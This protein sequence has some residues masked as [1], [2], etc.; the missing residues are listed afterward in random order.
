MMSAGL[1]AL[2]TGVKDAKVSRPPL[3]PF[4]AETAALKVRMA[5]D[6]WERRPRNGAGWRARP[7]PMKHEQSVQLATQTLTRPGAVACAE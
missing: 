2:Q 3:P 7:T 5:E 1:P 4:T 6:A